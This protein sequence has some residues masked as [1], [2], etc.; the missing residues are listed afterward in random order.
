MRGHSRLLSLMAVLA[1][2]LAAALA[3]C[4]GEDTRDV[5]P[6]GEP[7]ATVAATAA[8]VVTPLSAVTVAPTAVAAP[9]PTP[10]TVAVAVVAQTAAATA[11]PAPTAAPSPSPAP[12]P[13][14]TATPTAA[15]TPTNTPTPAPTPTPTMG[16]N[17]AGYSAL[18][19]EAVSSYPAGVDFV[20]DGL[21]ADERDVLDWADSRLFSN[22][23]FLASK[24][25]PDTWP[26]AVKLAS[27]Q[28]IPLLMNAIGIEKS[29]DGKHVITWEVDGLDR[30]L[31]EMGIYE[32][33]CVTCYG[34]ADYDTR[35][36]VFEN[37][38]PIVADPQHVHREMLKTFAYFA[39]A[40]GEGILIR[41]LMENDADDYE[42]LYN[43]DTEELLR[44]GSVS[45]T[46]F[47][48]RNLSFMSQVK[49]PNGIVKSFPT[50]VY[51]VV[52]GAGSEREAA[53]RWFGHLNRVMKHYTG[54]SE[55]VA[56]LYRPYSQTPHN[57]K[58]GEVLGI[59]KEADSWSSTG[60]TASAFRSLGLKA[61]QFLSP[62]KRRS[63]GAVEV[64]GKWYYHNGNI[65]LAVII[66]PMCAFFATLDEVENSNYEP[67][68]GS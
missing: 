41:S 51:E 43:R 47:G 4:V 23:N 17:L 57:P 49:L 66:V 7:V 24:Y 26:L 35:D 53:E 2:L 18:L 45:V 68:C 61:E 46:E 59:V 15:P 55:D 40:D 52:G 63:T 39:K 65:P 10:V 28:A 16:P 54:S 62:E 9:T 8:A 33:V 30:I 1:L 67:S 31:D 19:V 21:S 6:A 27:V 11:T 32:G 58:P 29:S 3:S 34:K 37:Y 56:N 44:R 5:A 14:P 64:D 42:L 50:M 60:L 22:T 36:K 12:T 25:G 48:W 13:V 20:S 38:E